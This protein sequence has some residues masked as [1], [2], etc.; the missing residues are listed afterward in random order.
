MLFFKLAAKILNTPAGVILA[1]LCAV[2]L[3]VFVW[4]KVDKSSA[5]RHAVAEYVADVELRAVRARLDELRRRKAVSDGANHNLQ[6]EVNKVNAEAEASAQELE[7]Y[8]S[9]VEDGCVVQPGLLDRLRS[10]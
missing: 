10:R 1:A 6:I 8:V 4:H 2:S 3:A 7:R 5:V 9:T